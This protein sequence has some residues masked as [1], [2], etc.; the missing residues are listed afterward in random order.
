MVVGGLVGEKTG[1]TA[2]AAE[3]RKEKTMGDQLVSLDTVEN[4][5]GLCRWRDQVW[6]WPE[7]AG[8]TADGFGW[9]E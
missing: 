9:Q 7:D 6:R 1:T 3:S 2:F 8:G 5:R 4:E